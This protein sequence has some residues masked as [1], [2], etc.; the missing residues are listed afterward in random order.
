MARSALGAQPGQQR[1]TEPSA[2]PLSST[3]RIKRFIPILLFQE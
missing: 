2:A 3:P 1:L